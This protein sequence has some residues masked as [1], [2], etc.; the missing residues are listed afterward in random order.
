MITQLMILQMMGF[1][2][3]MVCIVHMISND[4]APVVTSTTTIT[5]GEGGGGEEKG[6][7][8]RHE[9]VMYANERKEEEASSLVVSKCSSAAE[10]NMSKVTFVASVIGV[11]CVSTSTCLP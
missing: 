8:D 3:L 11:I 2:V 4:V 10:A 7:D 5:G 6:E 9:D 1:V